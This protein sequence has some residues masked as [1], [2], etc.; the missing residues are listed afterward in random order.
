VHRRGHGRAG[1]DVGGDRRFA[2]G[3]LL[4]LVEHIGRAALRDEDHAG[5]I[6][7]DQI[8]LRH[9]DTR[10]RDHSPNLL[11][12]Q[13]TAG[14][15]RCHGAGEDRKAIRVGLGDIAACAVGNDSGPPAPNTSQ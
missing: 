7:N 14:R 2:G 8:A 5:I 13:A 9:G 3:D 15:P 11:L 10:D 1:A 6:G 12:P 4:G